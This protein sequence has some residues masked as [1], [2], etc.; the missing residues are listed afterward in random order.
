MRESRTYGSVRGGYRKVSV[1]SINGADAHGDPCEGYA[2]N[3][4]R[5]DREFGYGQDRQEKAAGYH[6]KRS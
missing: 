1:Y 3:A 4:G 5:D 2:G 6:Q